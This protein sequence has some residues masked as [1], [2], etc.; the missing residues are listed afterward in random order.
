MK[1]LSNP[2]KSKDDIESLDDKF[3]NIQQS[4][5]S[6]NG[7]VREQ[8]SKTKIASLKGV[9]NAP[10]DVDMDGLMQSMKQLKEIEDWLKE[11]EK[12]AKEKL[13]TS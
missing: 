10:P 6:I 4:A 5:V 2:A 11:K 13:K 12:E 7:T 8:P 9:L 3:K 1:K